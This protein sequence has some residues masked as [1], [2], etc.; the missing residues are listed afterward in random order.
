MS[1]HYRAIGL[2]LLPLLVAGCSSQPPKL[3]HPQVTGYN[4]TSAA[5]NSFTINGDGGPN[6][7]PHQGGVNLPA[8]PQYLANG[9]RG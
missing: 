6:L 1:A 3:L 9:G 5:I 2:L 4:H 7:G 8:A